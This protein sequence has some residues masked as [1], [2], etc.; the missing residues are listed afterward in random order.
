MTPYRNMELRSSIHTEWWEPPQAYIPLQALSLDEQQECGWRAAGPLLETVCQGEETQES[1]WESWTLPTI[2]KR[3]PGAV[4]LIHTHKS[5]WACQCLFLKHNIPSPITRQPQML[6]VETNTKT[7][8]SMELWR[9]HNNARNEREWK[10]KTVISPEKL[11]N[12][13]HL[14]LSNKIKEETYKDRNR[15]WNT[16]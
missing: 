16:W 13:L 2:L 1:P 14:G 15:K 8:F 10:K 12:I 11:E 3:Y 6:K 9:N 4:S 5:H 7:K